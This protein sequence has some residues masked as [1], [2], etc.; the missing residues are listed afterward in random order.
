MLA[1]AWARRTEWLFWLS[2]RHE[3]ADDALPAQACKVF[4]RF[5]ALFFQ[6]APDRFIERR[7]VLLEAASLGQQIA[8]EAVHQL[9]RQRVVDAAD[10]PQPARGEP[11]R[12]QRYGPGARLHAHDLRG[13]QQHLAPAERFWSWQIL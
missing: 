9:L 7:E 2:C 11:R 5:D 10:E 3:A 8:L 12:E 4:Q 6:R 1:P 13:P